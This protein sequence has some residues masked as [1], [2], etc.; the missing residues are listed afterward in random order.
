MF[1]LQLV[2]S[3]KADVENDIDVTLVGI[4]D[5]VMTALGIY[6]TAQIQCRTRS[7]VFSSSVLFFRQVLAQTL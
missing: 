4:D 7:P 5:T 3:L 2:I 1:L 6:H